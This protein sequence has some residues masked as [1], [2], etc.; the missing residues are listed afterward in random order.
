MIIKKKKRTVNMS[1][2]VFCEVYDI[3]LEVISSDGLRYLL[4]FYKSLK[5]RKGDG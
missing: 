3:A 1:K 5:H 4:Y 2:N